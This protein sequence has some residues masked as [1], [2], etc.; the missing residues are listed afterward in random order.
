MSEQLIPDFMKSLFK[1]TSDT[2]IDYLELGIDSILSSINQNEL[3]KEIP[4]VKSI[5]SV[6]KVMHDIHSRN[7]LRQ[8]LTF[9]SEFN[10]RKINHEKYLKYKS[11]IN[12]NSKKAEDELG[13]VLL[14][15][16]SYID[17]EKSKILGKL[18]VAY[19][20]ERINWKTF[21]EYSEITSRI[22]IQD[23]DVLKKMQNYG[24][25]DV[26]MNYIT[27]RLTLAGLMVTYFKVKDGRL[28]QSWKLSDIGVDYLSIIND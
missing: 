27:S 19:V 4:I 13:R 10:K 15:L 20:N 8:T 16:D 1:D 14:L 2:A 12:N 22:F 3:V 28:L 5:Y 7:L 25:D 11:E 26:H 18:F 21:C 24:N 17:E 23:I 9:I 6:G